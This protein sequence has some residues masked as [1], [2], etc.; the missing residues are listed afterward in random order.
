METATMRG[1]KAIQPRADPGGF[2]A[3][4]LFGIWIIDLKRF[5]NGD[6]ALALSSAI[7]CILPLLA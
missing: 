6:C 2:G 5:Q 3:T 7:F 4:R 1:E